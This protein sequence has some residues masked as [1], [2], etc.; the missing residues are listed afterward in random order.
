MGMSAD[1]T[2]IPNTDIYLTEEGLVIKVELAGLSKKE[3]ELSMEAHR[4]RIAG[5][6]A[7][8]CRKR[9]EKCEFIRMEINYGAFESLIAIPVGYDLNRASAT[10]QNGFLR[11]DVPAEKRAI[12]VTSANLLESK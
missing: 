3:L 1:N 6:R 12:E 2:W 9:T 5:Q 4:L 11:I 10:Y 7:D 8:C